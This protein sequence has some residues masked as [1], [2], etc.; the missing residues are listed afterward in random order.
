[1]AHARGGLTAAVTHLDDGPLMQGCDTFAGEESAHCANANFAS[2]HYTRKHFS[3]G[4][5][6]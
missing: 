5:R 4:I 3:G 6:A 1:M 2:S